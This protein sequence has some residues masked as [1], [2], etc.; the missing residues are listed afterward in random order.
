MNWGVPVRLF[1]AAWKLDM[2]VMLD[3]LSGSVPVQGLQIYEQSD[4]PNSSVTV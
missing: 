4:G 1:W 3:Q 2:L